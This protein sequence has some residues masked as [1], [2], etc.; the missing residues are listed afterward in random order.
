M[1]LRPMVS[2]FTSDV[3]LS[4]QRSAPGMACCAFSVE[5]R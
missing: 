4:D 2:A 1:H 3:S 5:G